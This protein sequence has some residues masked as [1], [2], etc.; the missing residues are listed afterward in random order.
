VRDAGVAVRTL[1]ID[2]GDRNVGLALSDALGM[3]AQPLGTYLF[4]NRP[5]EDAAYFKDLIVSRQ[6]GAIVIGLPLRMDGSPGSRV[7]KTKA[8][9]RW[10]GQAVG[11]PIDFWDERLTTHQ[12]H[13]VMQE[14]KVRM[15]D[16][17]SVV[18]QISAAIILQGY[19]DSRRDDA[20]LS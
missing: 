11:V 17:R 5:A 10:L 12:A 3:T 16:K 7:D 8:F 15:K 9:A 13:Q 6:V 4:K 19:L 2:Y 1:G 14:Q 18:N 20:G